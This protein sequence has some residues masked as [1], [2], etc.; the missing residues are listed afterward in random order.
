[1]AGPLLFDA[2][3]FDLDG[4][5]VA[6]DR[7]W[8]QAART[9]ARRAFEELGL[10]VR[11]PSAEEWMS[12]V[13]LKLEDGFRA[14][15]PDLEQDAR[16]AVWEAC[17]EEE[18]RLLQAGGAV[19]MPGAGAALAALAE[20]GVRLGIASNC[21]RAY[22]DH[23]LSTLEL[24]RTIDAAYCLDSDGVQNKAD[25]I[26]RLLER[27]GTRAAVMVGDR[28][29]DR[30]AAWENGLPHVHCAFG[31]AP[32]GET[33]GSEGRIED[34]GELVPRLGCRTAWV[35]RALERLGALGQGGVGPGPLG[36]TGG[37]VAGKTLFARDAARV[38][39]ARGRA[40]VA[41]DLGAYRRPGAAGEE[42]ELAYDLERLE[43]DLFA[44][45]R[46][47]R[48]P[49]LPPGVQDDGSAAAPDAT[50]VLDG[51]FLLDPWFQSRLEGVVHLEIPEEL[52]WRR[53]AGRDGRSGGPE[54]LQTVRAGLLP[55]VRAHGARY[56]PR[57]LADLVLDA[58]NPL[59]DES[60]GDWLA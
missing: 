60:T 12:L 44:P 31:F 38:L 59:G 32:A 57:E 11:L 37:V 23:M 9:G 1:M 22:L 42:V 21:S 10:D 26:A 49:R 45:R 56:R 24:D 14:L 29:G 15:F 52:L 6:T 47:G 25:M 40:A 17:T 7:F 28:V 43:D 36:V 46:N 16:R 58:S 54:A 27:F 30:D 4:T 20:A 35:E 34:L 33:V 51:S 50:L 18:E 41:V 13:G 19:L 2:V 48:A 5:L 55:A 53:L 39:R 3:L 8:V